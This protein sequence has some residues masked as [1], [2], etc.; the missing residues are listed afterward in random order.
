MTQFW[1]VAAGLIALAMLF[2]IPTLLR[3]RP[4]EDISSN[5][6]NIAVIK[7][8]LA[9]LDADLES[10]ELDQEHYAASRQDLEK[11]LL[12]D[13]SDN[14]STLTGNPKAGRF[15]IAVLLLAIPAMAIPLY[16]TL[17]APGIIPRLAEMPA[18]SSP[19]DP[20]A[21]GHEAPGQGMASMIDL[22]EKLAQRL[23][24]EPNNPDGWKMLGRS[25]VALNRFADALQAYE[26]AYQLDPNDSDLLLGYATVLAQ[27]NNNDFTGRPAELIAK[28][29]ELDP[30][31]P[32][33]LWL[34]GISHFQ[35]G[36]YPQAV[37]LW[38]QV[39]AQLEPGSEEAMS[40]AEYLR[41]ARSMLPSAGST[42]T[43]SASV[44]E[45]PAPAQGAAGGSIQ[46]EVRLD[47]ALRDKVQ[48]SDRVF[49][50]AR[51]LQGP[52]M[53]LAA[54]RRQVKDLPVTLVLDDGMAM[55][56][57]LVL[58]NFDQVVVGARISKS[59]EAKPQSGDLQGEVS[60][61]KPGQEG[62]IQLVVNSIVP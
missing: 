60:P 31:N 27:T 14:D 16:L 57:Q 62:T 1:L 30:Q 20:A 12:D 2:F 58:S 15:A 29:A 19:S 4:T 51:A 56:P 46:V 50:F 36:E 18:E 11:E 6:L 22:V 47:P 38:E 44:Q 42:V 26:K 7:Q 9:E 39:L 48:A 8:Q 54:V 34:R 37:Q 24:Q 28:A 13:T 21:A 43:P 45:P 59:G 23:E 25:Y 32:N 17:G 3:K 52:P 40:V 41:E 10:G 35:A 33:I 5:E 55:M 49:I 61:V 53:P